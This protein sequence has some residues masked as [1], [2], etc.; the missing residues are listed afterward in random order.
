MQPTDK[1]SLK[2]IVKL[3]IYADD[4]LVETWEDKNLIVSGGRSAVSAL[5]GNQGVNKNVDRIAVG[6]NGADPILADTAVTDQVVKT[7]D[8][9]TFPGTAVQ[10]A[11]TL[12]TTDANG[13]T[14]REFALLCADNTLFSRV[15]RAPII[16]DNTVRIEGTWTITF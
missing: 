10:F 7:L 15:T 13:I 14:I 1:L 3:N 2:G 6:T 12:E 4:K 16:K 8:G 5:L 9:I 11:F